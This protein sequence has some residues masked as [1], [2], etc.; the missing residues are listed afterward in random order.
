MVKLFVEGGGDSDA[1]KTECRRA[2][3][4]L[5]ERAGLK[6]RMPRIVACGGRRSAFDQFCTA[7]GGGDSADV[8]ILLVDSEAPVAQG[9]PWEHVARRSGDR[10]T[11][12]KDVSDD[13]L[14][15]MVQ[16]ME[17]WLLADRP[18]L[19]AFYGQ[20][21]NESALPAATRIEEVGKNDLGRKLE[22][23]TRNTKTKGPY[24][25]GKHSFKLLAT[26]DPKLIREASPWAE[27]F[28]S[29]LD[30]LMS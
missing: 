5:L 12:P 30:R 2:F 20:G 9:S 28:F 17:A 3:A 29:A 11:R 10:W 27:R 24:D 1:L 23:A 15:F 8:A 25:K 4:R 19:R 21:F 16:C 7:L 26:L 18:A 13:G 14:H 22:Q 6:N